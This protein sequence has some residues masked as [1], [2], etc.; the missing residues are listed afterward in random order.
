[1]YLIWINAVLR[2]W[3]QLWSAAVCD[4]VLSPVMAHYGGVMMIL[5]MM[6]MMKER[7]SVRRGMP[8]A[9]DRTSVME[10]VF[11]GLSAAVFLNTW[12][13]FSQGECPDASRDTS[14]SRCWPLLLLQMMDSWSAGDWTSSYAAWWR[15]WRPWVKSSFTLFS[16]LTSLFFK[17]WC[18]RIRF[19]MH[20]VH[21][22]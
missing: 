21:I 6:M 14:L 20:E 13:Q 12:T 18:V 10:S 16:S 7:R 1:M 17:S 11:R 4:C 22:N 19:L 8:A 2:L 9:G 15:C 3:V 5:M